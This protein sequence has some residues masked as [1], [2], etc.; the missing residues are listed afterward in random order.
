MFDFD[1]DGDDL[2]DIVIADVMFGVF[3]DDNRAAALQERKIDPSYSRNYE[4][5]YRKIQQGFD[6][7]ERVL[8]SPS[9]SERALFKAYCELADAFEL[10][11]NLL[12][13]KLERDYQFITNCA[14]QYPGDF[15]ELQECIDTFC[16]EFD[17]LED[18]LSA[19]DDVFEYEFEE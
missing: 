3:D 11:F 1:N 13:E 2:E 4:N 18:C 8:K 12:K 6:K 15:P 5:V 14:E 9:Y 17:E 19:F 7:V 10:K 16:D